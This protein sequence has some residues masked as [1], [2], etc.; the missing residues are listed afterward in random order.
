MYVHVHGDLTVFVCVRACVR[1][2]IEIFKSSRAE[3]RT[4]YEPQRKVGGGGGG[5][6]GPYDRPSGG[7]GGGRGS[8]NGMNRG[9]GAVDR[10]RGGYG[11]RH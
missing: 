5:R 8:Y 9:G 7:G 4:H 6:P 10:R 11:G 1:S 3:V 2:Y